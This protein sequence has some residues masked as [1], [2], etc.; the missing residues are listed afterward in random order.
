M[1][2]SKCTIQCRRWDFVSAVGCWFCVQRKFLGIC[3][4]W[5]F[6]RDDLNMPLG[7]VHSLGY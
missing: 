5:I 7:S 4:V 2:P 1:G 6:C 3:S